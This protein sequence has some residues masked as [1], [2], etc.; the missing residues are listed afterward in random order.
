MQRSKNTVILFIF[1]GLVI[2]AVAWLFVDNFRPSDGFVQNLLNTGIPMFTMK[3]P[4]GLVRLP[5]RFFLALGVLLIF[6]AIVKAQRSRKAA[7]EVEP[8]IPDPPVQHP[9]PQER[10]EPSSANRQVDGEK[11]HLP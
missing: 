2:P 9:Q 5:F 11:D 3:P 4:I 10:S 8:G 6:I 7:E 1:L